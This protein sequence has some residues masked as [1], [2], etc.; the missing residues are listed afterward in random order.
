MDQDKYVKIKKVFSNKQFMHFCHLVV[1]ICAL[2][3]ETSTT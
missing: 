1:L 3:Y 2:K